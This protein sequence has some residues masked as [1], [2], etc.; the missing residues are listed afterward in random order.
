MSLKKMHGLLAT[1][2]VTHVTEEN[3]WISGAGGTGE[4]RAA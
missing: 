4:P 1:L 2:V 3:A